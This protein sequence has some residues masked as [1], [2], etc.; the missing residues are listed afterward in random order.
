[1]SDRSIV[2]VGAR[3]TPI[4]AFQGALSGLTAPALGGAAIKGALAHAGVDGG[5]VDEAVVGCCLF[6]GLRQAP[7]RQAVLAAGL[8]V[9]VPCTTLSKMCGSGMKTVM[10]VHDAL[11]AG[12]CEL[13]VAG[14]MESMS[15]A[16]YLLA[17]AREGYRLGH[18]RV[19]DHMFHDGLEDAYDGQLMGWYADLA[20][21]EHRIGRER[22][23]DYARE[24]VRR[25]QQAV[26][27]GAFDAEI[28]PVE[29]ASR[30]GTRR[31]S[32]DETPG[33]CDPAR[34]ATLKPAFR[35]EGTVTAA[36]ASSIS[37]GAAALVLA[38]EAGA[39]RRGAPPLARIVAMATH[40]GEPRH[41]PFAPVPAIEAVL[42][43]A[44]WRADDVDLF[45]INEA[46]AI[47]TLL[48]MDRLGLPAERVNVDGG[49]C[50]LG[51]P[52]G[53]TGARLLVTLIHS[54]ARRGLRRGVAALCI[55]GGEASAMAIELA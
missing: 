47:V 50:A 30:R 1:M 41:F 20:A 48:A 25:A 9:S 51:H 11:A 14:G 22:Q 27:E 16:P 34:I 49:A 12:S 28:V 2:I 39:A 38:T 42:R 10:Q 19:L 8:P 52:I 15:N 23:D 43:R 17:G 44:G 36:N 13:G 35:P 24:S 5:E 33:K 4:G 46:F 45:E 26:H 18:G 31:V 6:A 37:D 54:L 21:A 55:G 40:A 53:A 29:I 7:A 32:R 3:R